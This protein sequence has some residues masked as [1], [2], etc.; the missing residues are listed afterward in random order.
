MLGFPQGHSI[1]GGKTARFSRG[2][3]HRLNRLHRIAVHVLSSVCVLGAAICLLR[4]A[5]SG[6]SLFQPKRNFFIP[7]PSLLYNP[8]ET[9]IDDKKFPPEGGERSFICN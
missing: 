6:A 1:D 4:W 8:A 3:N 7:L 5:M 9:L 2:A